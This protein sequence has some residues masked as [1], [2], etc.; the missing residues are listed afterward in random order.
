[1]G[2]AAGGWTEMEGKVAEKQGASV[3]ESDTK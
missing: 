3:S 1:M 2:G